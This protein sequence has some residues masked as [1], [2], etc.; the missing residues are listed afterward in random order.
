[1]ALLTSKLNRLVPG[2]CWVLFLHDEV[3]D[4]LR[5]RFA[6]GLAAETLGGMTIP[7]GSGSSGWVA[8]HRLPLLNA[9]AAADF[10]AAGLAVAGPPVQAALSY[11]LVD[12]DHLIGVLTVYHVEANPFSDEHQ[13][14]LDQISSQ[15]ASVLKNAVAFERLRDV[16]LTDP[17]TDLPN[18]RALTAFLDEAL[19]AGAGRTTPTAIVVIDVDDFKTVNDVY[20]HPG[21]DAALRAVAATIRAQVREGEFCAR[22]G[23]D[24]FVMVLSGCDREEAEQRAADLQEVVAAQTVTVDWHPGQ[25]LRIRI[26]AGVGQFPADG[27]TIPALIAAADRRMYVDKAA[28]R[29]GA[30]APSLRLIASRA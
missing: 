10:E 30:R 13:H 11:P 28:R 21:G 19:A 14:V 3:E 22:Y 20:G 27:T 9:R 2:S 4:V 16:S 6:T 29:E 26:S 12:A 15:A 8:R 7:G 1:M 23:G 24:E 25:A 17:L 18:T 5:A